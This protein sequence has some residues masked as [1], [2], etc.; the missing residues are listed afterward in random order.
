MERLDA[1]CNKYGLA[2]A[3]VE[4]E[5]TESLN[6]VDYQK[7]KTQIDRVRQAG[8]QVSIDDFGIE[9]SNLALLSTAAFDVLKID[10]G[11]VKDIM[12][13]G[14]AR[15]VVEAMVDMCKKLD[16]RLVAE[17]V[18]DEKQLAVLQKCGVKIVQGFLFSRPLPIE[19]YEK[20]YVTLPA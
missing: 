13:N 1:V 5:V 4:I 16:I 17:G 15:T 10:K 20:I 2:K 7:L 9:C 18:E 14:N 12:I 3:Y 8:F 11:F 6:N 19:E